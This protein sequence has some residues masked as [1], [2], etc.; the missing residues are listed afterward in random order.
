[1]SP[2]TSRLYFGELDTPIDADRLTSGESTLARDAINANVTMSSGTLRLAYFTARKTETV[3]NVRVPC[4]GNAGAT[5]TLVRVGVYSVAA[6]G[7]LTLIGSTANNTAMLSVAATLYTQA[8]TT[9]FIKTAGLRYA[10]GL[11]VVTAAAAPTVPGNTL[12]GGIAAEAAIDPRR[13]ALF[14][15]QTDLPTPIAPGSLTDT[16]TVPYYVLTP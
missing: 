1:M 11:L 2:V 10:V 15:G 13:S 5:P 16:A 7:D 9:P 12:V 4:P 8:I 3:R 6:T 14:G